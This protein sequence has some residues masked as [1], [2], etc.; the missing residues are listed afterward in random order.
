M[1]ITDIEKATI[2]RS[3]KK[4]NAIPGISFTLVSPKV[5]TTNNISIKME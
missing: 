2:G 4:Y 3:V 1:A 5:N